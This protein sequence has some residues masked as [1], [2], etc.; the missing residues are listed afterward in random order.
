MKGKPVAD[1][2]TEKLIVEV[3]N[4]KRENII[5][6]LAI[7]RVGNNEEDLSYERGALKRCE[8]IGISTEVIELPKDVSTE[9]YIQILEKLNEDVEVNG[10]LCLQPLPKS[11]E[12][13]KYKINP[14]KDVDCF[15]PINFAKIIQ[16]DNTGFFPCTPSAVIEMLKFYN[17]DLKGKNV[18]VLGRSMIVGKP[19]SMMLVNEDAT[20]TICHSKTED[21]KNITKKCDIVISAIGKAKMIDSTFIKEGAIVVDVG[22]NVD[23]EGKLCGDVNFNSVLEKTSMITPVPAGVGSVTTSILAKNIIKACKLQNNK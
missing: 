10:I 13:I 20:V 7:I 16:Q 17:V 23:E 21:L 12:V 15:N 22:I 11:L 18:A 2:I 9:K 3:E 5:P 19:L 6:K 1:L 4:L 8:N 14:A